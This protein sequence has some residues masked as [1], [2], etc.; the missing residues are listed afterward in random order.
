MNIELYWPKIKKG[1]FCRCYAAV[2]P[3]LSKDTPPKTHKQAV[4][5]NNTYALGNTWNGDIGI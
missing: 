1:L 5:R 2:C 4:L 3:I